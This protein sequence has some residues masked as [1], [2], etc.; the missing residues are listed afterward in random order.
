[1]VEGVFKN[2]TNCNNEKNC[3]CSFN[4]IDLPILNNDEY[5]YLVNELNFSKQNFKQLKFNCYNI[6]ANNGVCPFYKNKCTIYKFRPNDCRLFPFD[7]KLINNK[8]YLILYKLNCYNNKDMLNENVDDIVNAIKP[9]IE[10]FACQE[11]NQKMS[12][13]DYI[14]IKEITL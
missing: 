1:M 8:Y 3:C 2:C 7:I 4:S 9:Y 13:Y 12:Q 10:T 11:L 5:N 14:I 6:M